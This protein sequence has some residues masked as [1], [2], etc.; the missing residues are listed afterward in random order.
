MASTEQPRAGPPLVTGYRTSSELRA[1]LAERKNWRRAKKIDDKLPAAAS[2]LGDAPRRKA[3]PPSE[4]GQV[5]RGRLARGP[6]GFAHAHVGAVTA[7][8]NYGHV[9]LFGDYPEREG[10]GAH[11]QQYLNSLN[12]QQPKLLSIR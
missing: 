10:H 2:A 7:R 6:G 3:F 1:S 8:I 11:P 5:Q 4:E 12:T 9:G